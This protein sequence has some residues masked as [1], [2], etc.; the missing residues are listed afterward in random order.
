MRNVYAL[1]LACHPQEFRIR[2]VGEMMSVFD[3]PDRMESAAELIV[4]ALESLTRQWLLSPSS[5]ALTGAVSIAGLQAWWISRVLQKGTTAEPI[6]RCAT[7][8]H[9]VAVFTM[10]TLCLVAVTTAIGVWSAL[11]LRRRAARTVLRKAHHVAAPHRDNNFPG[12]KLPLQCLAILLLSVPSLFAQN[13]P[14]NSSDK[15]PHATRF[16]VVD[17]DVKLELLDWGGEGRPLIFLAGAGFDA[18][19]F[20]EFAPKFTAHHH[21]FGITRRGS[22][23]SSAPIPT[24]DNYSSDQLGE[25]ILSVIQ[26]LKIEQPV[27]VGHSL[28]GEEMSYIGSRHPE[29]VAGLIYL[30]AAYSYAYYSPAIGDPIIDAMDL[31]DRLNGFLASG[32]RDEK[33]INRL[34]QASAQLDK[35]LKALAKQRAL[36]PPQPS[37]PATASPPPAIPLALSKGRRKYT[38]L[39]VPVLAIFA[40]PHD[41]GQLY[42]DDPKAK[43]A[44]LESDRETT[45]AQADAFQAGVPSA[46]VIRIANADHFVFRSNEAEVTR[47]MNTFLAGLS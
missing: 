5:W 7:N 2:F 10:A 20:D 42:K 25:D 6:T 3:E 26:N 13:P 38:Q 35:D 34:Q 22:G 44:V 21:V 14:S 30:D 37:R 39:R 11:L 41:F 16:V 18:H 32:F 33:D 29:A 28:A 1:I 47:Q 19:V 23:A 45:S 31:N 4:D 9:M 27:L 15:S 46:K 36:M 8:Q 40:D 17:K 24:G 43:A 12:M